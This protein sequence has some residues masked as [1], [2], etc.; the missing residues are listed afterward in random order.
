[1]LTLDSIFQVDSEADMV[2]VQIPLVKANAQEI[3]P[4]FKQLPL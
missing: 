2:I 1:M 3:T 4:D